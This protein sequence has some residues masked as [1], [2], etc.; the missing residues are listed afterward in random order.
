MDILIK[1]F[2]RPYYLDRCIQSIYANVLDY[3]VSITVLDDGT[4]AKYLEKIQSKFPKVKIIKSAF[5]DE[6]SKTIEGSQVLTNTNIPINLWFNAAKNASDYF[7]LL[8]DDIWFT[9]KINLQESERILND[10]NIVIAKLLWLDNPKLIQGNTKTIKENF[11]VYKPKV[12]TKNPYLHRLIFGITRFGNRKVMRFLQL[13]SDEKALN[14]YAIYGVAGAIF[15]KKYFLNLWHK[16]QNV[17]DE[18]LQLKNAVKFWYKS[19]DI[20]FA[21]TNEEF[22]ATG[23]MSSASNKSFNNKNFDM[24]QFNKIMNEAWF[25]NKF[26]VMENFPKDLNNTEIAKIL[27][28]ENN[29]NAEVNDWKKW[30]FDFKKQFQDIGCKI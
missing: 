22:L 10:E 2:N 24:F 1:S 11:T 25:Y 13:F 26:D 5:Y 23:F 14:Y 15:H 8:E 21:R 19:K 7:L 30:V 18:N 27:I 6:K 29:Q 4:P 3:S 20:N 16:H 9:K 12:F 17:V 28:H